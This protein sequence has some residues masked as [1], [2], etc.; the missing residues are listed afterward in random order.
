MLQL[1]KQYAYGV[2]NN[3]KLVTYMHFTSEY[4]TLVFLFLFLRFYVLRFTFLRFY[5]FTFLRFYV[6]DFDLQASNQF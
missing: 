4:I 5:V 2:L 6:F 1:Q 3:K